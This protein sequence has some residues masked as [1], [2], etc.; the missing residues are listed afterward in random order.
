MYWL[1]GSGGNLLKLFGGVWCLI[2]FVICVFR[3]LMVWGWFIRIFFCVLVF[4]VVKLVVK[5]LWGKIN[6]ISLFGYGCGRWYFLRYWLFFKE[7]CM[8]MIFIV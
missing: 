5:F 6:W 1:G 7:M 3:F 8:F 4:W 2:L